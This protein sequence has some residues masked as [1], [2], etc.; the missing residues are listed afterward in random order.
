MEY[1][2]HVQP[3]VLMCYLDMLDKQQK[4]V[5]RTVSPS[6]AA[7]LEP[8]AHRQ[9]VA[10]L[11]LSLGI[12]SVDDY[13]NQLSWLLFLFLVVSLLVI[14]IGHK[15][16]LSAFLDVI[17]M[18]FS[19]VSFLEEVDSGIL[20][21]QNVFL[22][23]LIYMT[24]TLKLRQRQLNFLLYRQSGELFRVGRSVGKIITIIL[25]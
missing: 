22:S 6:L 18:P 11:S 21:L 13:L 15:I 2:D 9:N 14:S 24:L 8:L 16:F 20:W 12:T 23:P 19:T 10:N 3:G 5:F 17:R 4:W 1:C 25:R 7:S